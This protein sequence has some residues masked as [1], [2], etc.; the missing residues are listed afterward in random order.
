M[1]RRGRPAAGSEL[2][3]QT[4]LQAAIEVLDERG[5][6]R[7]TLGAVATQV[8]ATTMALYR[9]FEGKQDLLDGA[10]ATVLAVPP[11][12]ASVEDSFTDLRVRFM[13][14]PWIARLLLEGRA[15]QPYALATSERM[16]RGLLDA[17]LSAQQAHVAWQL[18]LGILVATASQAAAGPP[19][20]P[21]PSLEAYP[22]LAQVTAALTDIKAEEM[23]QQLVRAILA[24]ART[25]NEP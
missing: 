25:I 6:E 24:G 14:H 3:A 16:V 18:M 1:T 22:S 12:G 2:D 11:A 10:V 19:P 5:P 4:W 20:S 7:F 21:P 17:G 9:H 23:P 8:G 13:A 15:S